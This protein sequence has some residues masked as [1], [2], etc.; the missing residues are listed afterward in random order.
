MGAGRAEVDVEHDDTD[1]HDHG[2]QYHTEEQEPVG[3]RSAWS[4][5]GVAG[6]G[7]ACQGDVGRGAV[8]WGWGEARWAVAGRK[9]VTYLPM[10]GTA[11]DVAGSR[12][13]MSSRKTDCASS[14]EIAIDVF[15]PP[16]GAWT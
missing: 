1:H 9:G 3:T 7:R 4:I 16:E 6:H 15:S 11:T 13:E 12:L 10:R 14:T 8:R 5:Q 2:H